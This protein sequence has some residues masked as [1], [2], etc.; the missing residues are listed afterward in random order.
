MRLLTLCISAKRTTSS[1][2]LSMTSKRRSFTSLSRQKNLGLH[3]LGIFFGDLIFDG[4]RN[5]DL[6]GLKENIARRHFCSP[7]GE[8]LKRL[9]LRVHPVDGLRHIKTFFIVKTAADVR[10]ADDFVA[11]FLHEFRGHGTNVAEALNHNAAALLLDTEFRERFVAAN[12]HPAAGGFF[13]PARSAELD[14]LASDDRSGGLADV[15]RVGVHHPSHGLLA[16]AHV[17]RWNVALWT[18]PIR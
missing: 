12:H 18:K 11:G 8:I 4:R 17:W 7:T 10:E 13:P 6:A 5:G 1:K 9:L 16:R 14:R 2:A 3:L 15:H